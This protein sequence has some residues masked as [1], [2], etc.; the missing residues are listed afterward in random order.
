MISIKLNNKATLRID[1]SRVIAT[2]ES[3]ESATVDIYV[4]GIT[5]PFHI[6]Q[7]GTQDIINS[8]WYAE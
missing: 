5:Y 8:I 6:S 7:T 4:D 3:P 1:P 2:I